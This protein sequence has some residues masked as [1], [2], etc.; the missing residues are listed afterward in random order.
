MFRKHFRFRRMVLGLA[1]AALVAPVASATASGLPSDYVYG[2][3]KVTPSG[4]TQYVPAQRAGLPPAAQITH[5]ALALVTPLQAD[6]MRWNAMA[7]TY[8]QRQ[9]SVAFSE[10]SFGVP[11]PDP[12]LVPQL[13]ASTSTSSSFNWSDAG[14]GAASAALIA[15]VLLG[16]GI[17][18]I[19]RHQHTGLTS[20]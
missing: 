17:V 11:G 7:Q 8:L 16:V 20:A 6:G 1:F 10:R 9:P 19:R 5:Q 2:V 15:A 14:I 4:S 12:S 18:T 3:E 13:T